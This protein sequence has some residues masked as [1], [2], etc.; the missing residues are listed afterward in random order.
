MVGDVADYADVSSR[1]G[2]QKG[3]EIEF[4][5]IGVKKHYVWQMAQFAFVQSGETFVE[6]HGENFPCRAGQQ[7]SQVSDSAAD[8][9]NGG[10]F[11]GAQTGGNFLKRPLIDEEVL[12]QSLA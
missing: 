5:E 1:H 2:A 9:N 4:H 6:F 7:F 10:I 11:C 12:S 8:F 3:I